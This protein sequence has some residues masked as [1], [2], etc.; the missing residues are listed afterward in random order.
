MV[1]FS[2]PSLIGLLLLSWLLGRAI[3]SWCNHTGEAERMAYRAGY[4]DGVDR[5]EPEM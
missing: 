2:Y 4:Q 3:Q 1:E 5:R